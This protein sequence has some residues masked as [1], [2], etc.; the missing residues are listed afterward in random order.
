MGI[1]ERMDPTLDIRDDGTF[2]DMGDRASTYIFDGS[3]SWFS[4]G[5]G[6][7][8]P[9]HLLLKSI[10]ATSDDKWAP[11]YDPSDDGNKNRLE[12]F[13]IDGSAA[14]DFVALVEAAVLGT[15]GLGMTIEAFDRIVISAP[16]TWSTDLLVFEGDWV[17]DALLT[18]NTGFD[19]GNSKSEMKVFCFDDAGGNESIYTGPTGNLDQSEGAVGAI[20]DGSFLNDAGGLDSELARLI[21]AALDEKFG[22]G[23]TKDLAYVTDDGDSIIVQVTNQ[24]W[25]GPATDTMIL[26]GVDVETILGSYAA[27]FNSSVLDTGDGHS[28][29]AY[30]DT[31]ANTGGLGGMFFGGGVN[32]VHFDAAESISLN[33]VVGNSLTQREDNPN[34]E[35]QDDIDE[36]VFHALAYSGQKDVTV[37]AGGQKGDDHLT[38]AMNSKGGH[39]DILLLEG[40]R[41]GDAIDFY[42]ETGGQFDFFA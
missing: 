15:E 2:V 34:R 7:K 6:N 35:W 22:L 36:F 11:D 26:K 30:Y 18:A 21:Y 13:D 38:V 16:G 23:D 27:Q 17:T 37:I 29:L 9:A 42:A 33:D 28:R 12:L 3:E 19:L 32:I 41:I 4:V 25:K 39:V 10:S 24:H 8:G 1:A 20:L 5:L 31:D 14:D 40:D